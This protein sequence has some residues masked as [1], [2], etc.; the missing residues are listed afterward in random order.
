[1]PFVKA[2]L[3]LD[4]GVAVEN[5]TAVFADTKLQAEQN[6]KKMMDRWEGT[7]S[8]WVVEEGQLSVTWSWDTAGG[9]RS[10]WIQRKRQERWNRID[11]RSTEEGEL[12]ESSAGIWVGSLSHGRYWE[13]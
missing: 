8:N 2:E 7:E 9:A 5:M 6:S 12:E 13:C 11:K 10:G 1:M 3:C 4:T